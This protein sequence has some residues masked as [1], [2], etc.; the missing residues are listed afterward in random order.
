MQF[1][2]PRLVR[3][4]PF[5]D[6]LAHVGR[7]SRREWRYAQRAHAGDTVAEIPLER[8]SLLPWMRLWEGQIVEGRHPTW[9]YDVERFIAERYWRLLACS[10]GVH[11]LLVCGDYCYAGP[12]L[13]DK[14]AHPYAA[15]WMWFNAIRWAHE[16]GLAWLD[17]QGPGQTNWRALL[18]QPDASYKF[19]YVQEDI[20]AHPELAEP[21]LSQCCPCGYRQL[22]IKQEACRG[23]W[24]NVA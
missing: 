23:C 6:Y 1:R 11:P 8:T 21:W 18:E 12:P 5:D 16:Q 19:L 14:R 9:T 24:A 2:S 17:L 15:K 13:Y 20:R 7:R 4:E 10:I 22:V 3:L